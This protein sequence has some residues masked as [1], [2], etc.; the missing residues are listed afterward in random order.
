M[1]TLIKNTKEE[2]VEKFINAK[3]ESKRKRKQLVK[4]KELLVNLTEQTLRKKLPNTE[5]K[6]DDN[7]VYVY[8]TNKYHQKDF[9]ISF[10]DGNV[11]VSSPTL[12]EAPL[13]VYQTA[14]WETL[15][16]H[17]DEILNFQLDY[18][19][20]YE[21]DRIEDD[22][23]WVLENYLADETFYKMVKGESITYNNQTYQIEGKTKSGRY[24]FV[25]TH[26]NTYRDNERTTKNYYKDDIIS[27]VRDYVR[28]LVNE[29]VL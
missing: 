21:V 20:S 11:N 12:F 4:Q 1:E 10:S 15:L 28:Q 7:S 9:R 13:I 5:I 16:Q 25:I 2:L 18:M 8:T 22:C 27:K 14:I 24:S 6:T 3:E 29:I 26:N 17:Q 23:K 19:N